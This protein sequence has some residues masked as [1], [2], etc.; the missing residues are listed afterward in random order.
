MSKVDESAAQI[1]LRLED[2]EPTNRPVSQ[3]VRAEREPLSEERL[4]S[5]LGRLDDLQ[6]DADDRAEFAARLPTIPP[7][8]PHEVIE[9]AFPPADDAHTPSAEVTP[10]ETLHVVRAAPE[11]E[12][13]RIKHISVT[14]S[15][16]MVVL[17]TQDA[18]ASV[19]PASLTPEIP[20]QWRWVG[21]RT[22]LFEPAHEA[23]RATDFVL[24]VSAG[25]ESVSG[26]KLARGLR[27]Q[28]STPAVKL[29][30][31]SPSSYTPT[32]YQPELTLFFDQ[33]VDPDAIFGS[34]VLARDNVISRAV[35]L[36]LL[37]PGEQPGREPGTW[38]R[39]L[40]TELLEQGKG[41]RVTLRQGAPALQGPRRTSE[42]QHLSFQTAGEFKFVESR[43]GWDGRC[44]PNDGWFIRFTN[45]IDLDSFD[46]SLVTI[47][48]E[49]PSAKITC[50]GNTISIQGM[51]P[52]STKFTVTISSEL[53]DHVGQ[54]LGAPVTAKFK[55]GVSEPMLRIPRGRF[56]TLDPFG[57]PVIPV[58]TMNVRRIT[59]RAH[60]VEPDDYP[61]F[62]HYMNTPEGQRRSLPGKKVF[63]RNI[64]VDG[65]DDQLIE[66]AVGL[67]DALND[68]LGHVIFQVE[69]KAGFLAALNPWRSEREMQSTAWIQSTRL[70]VDAVVDHKEI[71]GR[72][73]SLDRGAPV[74]GALV[75]L[76]GRGID[77]Q[78][79]ADGL[80]SLKLD[81]QDMSRVEYLVARH[82]EDAALLPRG[83]RRSFYS[84]QLSEPRWR[85]KPLE[86]RVLFHV[87]DDRGLYKPGEEV[88]IKG[89]ARDVA[90]DQSAA[91]RALRA[92][93]AIEYAALDLFGNE[94]A[95]GQ[96]AVDEFGGFDLEV[97]TSENVTLGEARVEFCVPGLDGIA[98]THTFEIQEFRRPEFEVSASTNTSSAMVGEIVT[99]SVSASYFAG[100]ALP[101]ASVSWDVTA[102]PTSY[103]PPGWSDYHFGEWRDWWTRIGASERAEDVRASHS[104]KTDGQGAHHLGVIVDKIS[105]PGPVSVIAQ[106]TVEDVNRQSWSATATS[107]VHA[108]QH[109]IGARAKRGFV[110]AGE[111]AAFDVVVVGVD[112]ELVAGRNVRV[113]VTR[114]ELLQRGAEWV[115]EELEVA[116]ERFVSASEPTRYSFS[117]D[118]G[119]KYTIE[120][121]SADE[122]D[123]PT[124]TSHS[125]WVAGAKRPASRAVE[126][127]EVELIPDRRSYQPGEVAKILVVAPF[128]P[129]S[130]L[131]T[132]T[133]RGILEH[134]RFEVEDGTATLELEVRGAH[135]PGISVC[136]DLVGCVS[137]GDDVDKST[138]PRPAYAVGELELDV[139][140]LTRGLELELELA[141]QR[142]RPG[143]ETSL[144]LVARYPDGE[145]ARGANVAVVVVDEAILALS[146]YTLADPLSSFYPK[147][148]VPIERERARDSVRL[149]SVDALLKELS[150]EMPAAGGNPFTATLAGGFAESMPMPQ[151]AMAKRGGGFGAIGGML[152]AAF[153]SGGAP[154]PM[155]M[156]MP[157]APGAA[158][159]PPGGGG[160]EGAAEAPA[161]IAVRSNFDPLATFEAVVVTD[162][163]GEAQV[164]VELPD[165]LTRYRVMVVGVAGDAFFGVAETQLVAQLPL[166]VRPSAPRFL[167]F[168]DLCELPVVIQNQTDRPAQ[169]DVALRAN[170]LALRR[171]D[172]VGARVSVPADDRVEVRFLAR[173]VSAGV[174][175]FQVAVSSHDFAD[176]ARGEFP[177]WTPATAEAFATY[178]VIDDGV[179]AQ[180]V[181]ATHE[182]WPEFGGL[183]IST[184][185]T[186]VQAL[187]DAMIYL[188][189]YPFECAEQRASRIL[190]T[191]ALE[192]ILRAFDAD[193]LPD[194]EELMGSLALDFEALEQ[195]QHMSGG[196]SFWRKTLLAWPWVSLHVCHALVRAQQAGHAVPR[197]MLDRVLGYV[198]RI[199]VF[200][201]GFY[202][203]EARWA[204]R[205]YAYR[206]LALF[207][208]DVISEATELATTAGTDRLSI[209]SCGW[210]LAVIGGH[211]RSQ[212]VAQNLYRHLNNA[213]IETAGAARFSAGVYENQ[214]YLVLASERRGDAA[215][216]E[217]L[218]S[219]APDSDL[220]P[221][222][223]EGL[224]D[225]RVKGRWGSTQENC[226]VLLALERY[227][228]VY[229]AATPDFVARAWLGDRFVGEQAFEGRSAAQHKIDVPMKSVL[230]HGAG[231]PLV[232]QKHG[233]G[234]LY[235]RL[236]LRY[237]PRSLALDAADRGFVVQRRYE[238]VDD[239]ADVTQRGDGAWVIRAGALVR[240]R[241][242]MVASDRRYHVALVDPLPAG[243]EPL[244]PALAMTQDVAPEPVEVTP[245]S[246]NF[247][248]SWWSRTWFEHQNMRDERVEAF[249]SMLW[250][251][252]YTY[253]YVARA[254]TPGE[255]IAPPTRAEE[256]YSPEVF[257]RS[258]S[259]RVIVVGS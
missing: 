92:G 228:R 169:V 137:R 233:E 30:G 111:I 164:A 47:L 12:V 31:M 191:V 22:L 229:E 101:E 99:A 149:A 110:N 154:P 39:V 203:Q 254:T 114:R 206:V 249:A 103:S 49:L 244:N 186:A 192:P 32:N 151:M 65:D 4:A 88:R 166:M 157:S 200:I 197:A 128:A 123:A 175:R 159:A 97:E 54:R 43:C 251:G 67:H 129:A 98:H 180:P 83:E 217:G 209:E 176:A 28:F 218:M 182:V 76:D 18:A 95:R 84:P 222:V 8:R 55:T 255:F 77:G 142:V 50:S 116:T 73:T 167:N 6:G 150:D 20:G 58:Y 109:Y 250:E 226:H 187:T 81:A 132:I 124:V 198:R 119:G 59:V 235:Y 16:P 145:L 130:G 219:F 105:P 147:L 135:I 17:T 258:A 212:S 82:G 118:R 9:H 90:R 85:I 239:E 120:F 173:T 131:L 246:S 171:D 121:V 122:L 234:R 240:V 201:P 15:E 51:K 80:V 25:V 196:F 94:F 213:A 141:H 100:G 248:S 194:A 45:S 134:R 259:E 231:A 106:A 153:G 181:D 223:V 179:I 139:P 232:L 113:K 1:V 27:Q 19:V 96:V 64:I 35:P 138:P 170:N 224:L 75:R 156:S 78:S 91:L 57:H 221:K 117:S 238:A 10:S 161:P 205:A 158:F 24:E 144:G 256:M 60:R 199:T 46:P 215:A 108:S 125:L 214:G 227:F 126:L 155:P 160:G 243:L 225:G 241:L 70:G 204:I 36:E 104:A 178:G 37:E 115:E 245:G 3:L 127:E 208:D 34:L 93:T 146:G 41:Y 14:F 165:N 13:G 33:P 216:L 189:S 44:Q 163:R 26:A 71:L 56:I 193:G 69:P 52:P 107:L 72:V 21:T 210:L 252:V 172:G 220:I 174:A 148:D 7:P 61:D 53:T 247:W 5:L 102:K 211:P 168:G 162:D 202:S 230:E 143:G 140:P 38:I 23:P 79:D 190:S 68:G 188:S 136:V 112:G 207:G 89:W 66:T 257:G 48:P 2:G 242:T 152:D 177:V 29:T 87:F 42:N 185:S 183:E 237:A 63:E 86:R 133:R 184:S 74:H 62:I 195:Q 40:P 236:G 11:G 253:T